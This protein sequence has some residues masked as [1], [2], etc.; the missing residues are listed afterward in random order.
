MGYALKEQNVILVNCP[1]G[2]LRSLV[3]C[4]E[5]NMFLVG[6]FVERVVTCYPGIVLVMLLRNQHHRW[7][8]HSQ[9]R[10]A[11]AFSLPHMERFTAFRT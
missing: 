5:A 10:V 9:F 11:S 6:R 7:C 4:D 8:D 2:L 1:D 3:P